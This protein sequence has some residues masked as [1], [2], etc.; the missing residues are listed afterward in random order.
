[1]DFKF[2][3]TLSRFYRHNMDIT[4]VLE[5]NFPEGVSN[6]LPFREGVHTLK[7]SIKKDEFNPNKAVELDLSQRTLI[8]GY[9]DAS[10]DANVLHLISPRKKFLKRIVAS[11]YHAVA[12]DLAEIVYA[13]SKYPG[14][15]FII[16]VSEVR[17][18]LSTKDWDFVGYFLKCLDDK[19]IKYTLIDMSQLDVIYINDFALLAF[20][21]HSGARLDMLADFFKDY[22]TDPSQ[23]AYRK[24]LVSRGKMPW[25]EENKNAKNF[26]Y[27]DDNRID[28]HSKLEKV[29]EDLGFEI[30]Y[31]ED[32][33][34]FQEQIDFFYSVKVMASL[35]SSGIVNAVFMQPEGTMVE[36]VT[37]LITQSPV[38]STDY[39]KENGIDP[40]DYEIDINTV[41]EVHMFYHNLAFY[42]NHTYIA[43]PNYSRKSEEVRAFID[44][45]KPLKRMLESNE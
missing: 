38:V 40:K 1:M 15:E 25:R 11:Y 34:N 35:T 4:R 36:V 6:H 23:K 9:V 44:N 33:N 28:D 2:K 10:E 18:W 7:V 8:K 39:L 45:N 17:T 24:V 21:F 16:D 32:F 13:N 37:P 26:S 27:K 19:K 43:I 14:S 5:T 29:F 22:V 31:P 12:D 41:Q 20:P 3:K 42:K 30:V